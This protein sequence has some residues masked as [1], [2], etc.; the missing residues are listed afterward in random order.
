MDPK[1][2]IVTLRTLQENFVERMV[3]VGPSAASGGLADRTVEAEAEK[4]EQETPGAA[5][6]P[7]PQL[8]NL[9]KKGA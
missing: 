5:S 9:H 3:E 2:A 8:D 4:A 6:A 7:S 1:T